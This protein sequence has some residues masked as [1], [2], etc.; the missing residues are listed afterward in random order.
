M[1][2]FSGGSSFGIGAGLQHSRQAALTYW[3]LAGKR[4]TAFGMPS[5][6]FNLTNFKFLSG[7]MQDLSCLTKG[8][9]P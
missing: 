2:A 3:A 4:P 7:N 5:F 9:S 1:V 8:S 6:I